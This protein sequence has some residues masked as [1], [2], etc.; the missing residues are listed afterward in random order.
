MPVEVS[1]QMHLQS[2]DCIVRT[3][4]GLTGNIVPN[5]MFR[6]VL[7]QSAVAQRPLKLPVHQSGRENFSFFRFVDGKLLILADFVFAALQRPAERKRVFKS[8]R[9]ISD[10]AVLPADIAAGLLESLV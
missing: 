4:A 1:P 10:H 3:L 5:Q 9:L 7:I 6:D 2:F 8:V